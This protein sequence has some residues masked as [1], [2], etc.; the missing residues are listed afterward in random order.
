MVPEPDEPALPAELVSLREEL[1][2]IAAVMLEAE[3]PEL[4]DAPEGELP[5]GAE[6]EEVLDR[7]CTGRGSMARTCSSSTHPHARPNGY[8]AFDRSARQQART[9]KN[10]PVAPSAPMAL[11]PMAS[12][13]THRSTARFVSSIRWRA[14]VTT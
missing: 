8:A 5:W 4:P 14:V 12:R 10:W 2:R 3:V 9:M 13:I 7:G 6:E 1:D 11:I